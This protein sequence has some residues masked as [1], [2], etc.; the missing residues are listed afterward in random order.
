[1][2]PMEGSIDENF[3]EYFVAPSE[4]QLQAVLKKKKIIIAP[5]ILKRSRLMQKGGLI[6]CQDR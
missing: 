3:I 1:M 4:V 6:R 5:Y 2:Y